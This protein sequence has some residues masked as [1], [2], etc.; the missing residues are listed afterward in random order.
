[1]FLQEHSAGFSSRST[2]QF[3][4]KAIHRGEVSRER[5]TNREKCSCR[6]IV[7]KLA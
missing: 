4:L 2:E 5:V 1:M 7:E 6:N 3:W